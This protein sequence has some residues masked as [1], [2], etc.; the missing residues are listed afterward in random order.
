MNW[1][2]FGS[3]IKAAVSQC[4]RFV[5]AVGFTH[6]TENVAPLTNDA[7]V[8]HVDRVD[9][10]RFGAR[11]REHLGPEAA[12]QRGKRVGFNLGAGEVRA[13]SKI[14]RLPLSGEFGRRCVGVARGF[15]DHAL[16]DAGVT[17]EGGG[18]ERLD[19][20]FERGRI[21]TKVGIPASQTMKPQ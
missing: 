17:L 3:T 7:G 13:G 21:T 2:Y 8:A 11:H 18:H 5:A 14:Q 9:A 1:Q 12:E 19:W 16:E 20:V 10:L 15:D 4:G 6:R